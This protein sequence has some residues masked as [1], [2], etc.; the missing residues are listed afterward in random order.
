MQFAAAFA[1][2]HTATLAWETPDPTSPDELT[3][4]LR[5]REPLGVFV[6]CND[7]LSV[8]ADVVLTTREHGEL[9]R[10][11]AFLRGRAGQLTSAR[12]YRTGSL[13][14][15]EVEL[16]VIEG[17]VHIAGRL[18]TRDGALPAPHATFPAPDPEDGAAGG[19]R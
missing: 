16:F 17:A 18:T 12:L 2:T 3:L 14:A 7:D 9:E 4:E 5:P 19:G 6:D 8:V 10:F 13:V 15:L 1:G 11:D